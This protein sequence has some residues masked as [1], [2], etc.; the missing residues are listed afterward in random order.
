MSVPMNQT[1]ISIETPPAALA[2]DPVGDNGPW[3]RFRRKVRE[4]G[5]PF[6]LQSIVERIPPRLFYI[7][8]FI[9]YGL[10]LKRYAGAVE[11]DPLI[12]VAG[13]E[14]ATLLAQS[15]IPVA[16]IRRRLDSDARAYYRAEGETLV[17]YAWFLPRN[18][19]CDHF[20]TLEGLPHDLWSF[21]GWVNPAF[22]G[23]GH[24]N[25]LKGAGAA[26]F[27]KDGF[28]RV[29]ANVDILNRNS[30]NANRAIGSREVGRGFIV[31]LCGFYLVRLGKAL[32]VGRWRNGRRLGISL[33][34]FE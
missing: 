27:A 24:F 5:L 30:R 31:I 16:E 7:N 9:I 15:G 12:E 10:D 17:G 4:V 1:D 6:A 2:R 11:T 22:R 29:L 28:D 19:P 13:P 20:L 34:C 14:R 3:R 25:R 26:D 32:H 33:T 8:Y 18:F 21:D 23:E